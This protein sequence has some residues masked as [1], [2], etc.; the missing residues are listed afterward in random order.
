MKSKHQTLSS[1]K[2][3]LICIHVYLPLTTLVF[4]YMSIRPYRVQN[5]L[6]SIHPSIHLNDSMTKCKQGRFSIAQ[7]TTNW[8]EL[9]C[10]IPNN[11]WWFSTIAS[12]KTSR[13]YHLYQCPTNSGKTQ[14]MAHYQYSLSHN[15]TCTRQSKWMASKSC[16]TKRTMSQLQLLKELFKDLPSL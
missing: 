1:R 11:C 7:S 13:F 10:I 6:P 8:P 4:A 12:T 14:K 16:L 9:R 3:V 15:S 5:P 2:E